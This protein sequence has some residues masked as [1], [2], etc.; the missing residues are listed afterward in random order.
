MGEIADYR[1]MRLQQQLEEVNQELIL[2][3]ARILTMETTLDILR[4]QQ[5][6]IEQDKSRLERELGASWCNQEA[7]EV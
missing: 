6:L 5:R 2:V 7:I 4:K 1:K 3:D